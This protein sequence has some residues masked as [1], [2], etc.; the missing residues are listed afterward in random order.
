MPQAVD[1]EAPFAELKCEP[2]EGT[3]ANTYYSIDVECVATGKLHGDRAVAQVALVDQWEN[4]ILNIYVKP[5]KP[6]TSYLYDLTG[7]TPEILENGKDLDEA[8]KML[9][10]ALPADCTLVGQNILMDVQ[11]MGLKEGEDFSGM[12][13]LAGLFRVYNERFKGWSYHSLQHKAKCLLGLDHTTLGSKTH[14][15]ATD[16]IMSMRLYWLFRHLETHSDELRV[17]QQ[18]L[19][20]APS[21][22]SFA[23]LNAEYEGVCMGNRKTCV[24]GAPFFF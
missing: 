4:V 2:Q 7:L 20:T 18:T 12:Q 21:T 15:A 3:P 19:L 17:S 24:C 22:P 10:A 13:D 14:N 11:W 16:A 6:I 5:D 23:T 8:K 1:S 9:L